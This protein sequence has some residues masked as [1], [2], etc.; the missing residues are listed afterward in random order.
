MSWESEQR[1]IH[2]NLACKIKRNDIV[3]I[4]NVNP[5][6]FFPAS[7]SPP[8]PL[9]SLPLG[10]QIRVNRGEH[11]DQR[12]VNCQIPSKDRKSKHSSVC[13]GLSLPNKDCMLLL[14]HAT[15]YVMSYSFCLEL[16]FSKQV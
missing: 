7:L 10:L 16:H 1:G 5:F 4:F 11:L 6:F 13:R 14:E 2:K 9:S 3:L 8:S 12:L 15:P